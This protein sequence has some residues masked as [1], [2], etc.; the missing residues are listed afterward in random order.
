[1]GLNLLCKPLRQVQYPGLLI[2]R[3]VSPGCL[4]TFGGLMVCRASKGHGATGSSITA[5]KNS[6]LVYAYAQGFEKHTLSTRVSAS[7]PNAN[8]YIH[9]YKKMVHNRVKSI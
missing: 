5:T 9:I 1:M 7:C 6:G 2:W 3:L 8:R 4:C